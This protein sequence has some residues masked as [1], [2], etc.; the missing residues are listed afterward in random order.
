MR[1]SI[2][3]CEPA[4]AYAGEKKT[5][6]F[7]YTT[8]TA[9]PEGTKLKF[10]ILSEGRPTDWE[11]PEADKKKKKNCIYLITEEG[12]KV[13]A[14]EVSQKDTPIPQ[15]EF[16]LPEALESEES[17]TIYVGAAPSVD[18]V[19]SGNTC[20][21]HLQRRRSFYL[22]ID[23]KGK[24]SYGDPEIF[25]LDVKGAE[26]AQIRA[27]TPSFVVRNKRFDVVL[28][29]EDAYGNFTSNTEEGTLID[30]S[31]DQLR[32]NLNWKLFI[33][34]TG[35]LAIPNLYFN[36]PGVYRL[37][38]HNTRTD[39][40][41]YS[42]PIKC[43]AEDSPSLFW[44]L[45]HGESEKYDTITDIEPCLRHLRDEEALNFFATS[46]P[47]NVEE[48]PNDAWK[49]T[50]SN[51]AQFN[52]ED[53]F[54]SL[55]GMQWQGEDETEGLR[56]LIYSKDS[57]PILRKKDSKSNALK[58]IYRTH[59]PKDL[60]SIPSFTASSLS[61]FDF[62][63]F[64]PEFERLVEIYN[65]WGSS[66]CTAKQGNPFPIQSKKKL[67][68]KTYEKGTLREALNAGHRFGFCAGGLDDRGTY[69][70]LMDE[71]QT[72]FNPGLTAVMASD[73]NRES[74]FEA[75][76]ERRTIATTGPRM[77]IGLSLAG[78]SIGSE[79]STQAKPGLAVNRHLAGF[80]VGTDV[81]EKIELIR[82]GDVLTTFRPDGNDTEFTYDDMDPLSQV[83]LPAGVNDAPFVYYY[84]R[85]FQKDGNIGWTTPIWVDCPEGSS[86]LLSK[87]K[88][89]ARK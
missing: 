8:A 80:A 58:K 73:F 68:A 24:G 5:W 83:A 12:T 66:E 87:P 60:L 72:Q 23:T 16:T 57:K 6:K 18:E 61:P 10:D 84:L 45:L 64:N 86:P 82:N 46:H 21:C 75:L 65:A 52:E 78:A 29:F 41:F 25:T 17:F 42:A 71:D 3:V 77:L 37:K 20:Q 81:L 54:V 30:L 62:K 2:A 39:E 13:Y 85:V 44:G 7:I 28:R 36:E 79:L 31:Y 33:P 38:L 89:K 47:E 67:G 1:R 49:Q 76:Y 27:I 15:F 22:Y 63:E 19:T 50:T 55:L 34:E 59:T 53:R 40:V 4:V 26:L 48:T 43:F 70:N 11:V 69:E 74:L 9:L 32:E 56:Q 88:K 51:I 35:Y 14:D